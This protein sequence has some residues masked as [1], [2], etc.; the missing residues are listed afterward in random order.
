[1]KKRSHFLVMTAIV[2]AAGIGIA[3]SADPKPA[4]ADKLARQLVNDY[5]QIRDGE[6]VQLAGCPADIDLLESLA[7]AVRQRGGHPLITLNSDRLARRLFEEVPARLNSK[8]AAFDLKLAGIIDARIQTEFAADDALSGVTADQLEEVAREQREV[9]A[10][11]RKR[12]V[13]LIWL[14]NGMYPTPARARQ[15]G[16]TTAELQRVFQA[17]LEVDRNVLHATGDRL[18]N[19]LAAGKTIHLTS[20]AG[21]DLVLGIAN[22]P[23]TISDGVLDEERKRGEAPPWTWLP[24]GEVYLVPVPG[25]GEGRIVIDRYLFGGKEVRGLTVTVKGGQVV[26]LMARSGGE[27]IQSAFKVAEKGKEIVSSLDFGINPNV[28]LPKG[29]PLPTNIPAGMVAVALGNNTWAG[30]D[31]RI[32]FSLPLFVG[33]ATVTVDGA[34][35]VEGGNLKP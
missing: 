27:A 16:L 21:T 3:G 32:P 24:A 12:K 19:K 31:I 4:P 30:G 20:P 23:I 15:A 28:R 34:A 33:D 5:A 18:R 25:S 26:D 22:R 14:G 29:C 8:A 6:F 13:R 35:I 7:V 1:M 2:A 9:Y 17:G 11:L 10:L